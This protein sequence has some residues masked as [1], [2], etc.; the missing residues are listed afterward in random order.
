MFSGKTSSAHNKYIENKNTSLLCCTSKNTR[1][2]YGESKT[3]NGNILNAIYFEKLSDIITHINEKIEIIIIDEAQF[4]SDLKTL[5]FGLNVKNVTEIHLYGL[6]S[7]YNQKSFQSIVD[8]LPHVH[9]R[10]KFLKSKCSKCHAKNT[11]EYSM[12]KSKNFIKNKTNDGIIIGGEDQYY[13]VCNT[14]YLKILNS[15]K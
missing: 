6:N 8:I 9:D 15:K 13:V 3:H 2:K 11:S 14:C 7:D 4:V 12:L 10:M 5:C 1:D